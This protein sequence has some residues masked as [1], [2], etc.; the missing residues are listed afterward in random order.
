[1]EDY[2]KIVRDAIAGAPLARK[3]GIVCERVVV[4]RVVMRL[5]WTPEHTT[6]GDLVHGGA[7][8]ALVDVAA[9]GACWATPDLEPGARGTTIGFTLSFLNAGRAQDLLARGARG[10]ARA[11]DRHRRG[12]RALRRRQARRAGARHLQEVLR[13][14]VTRPTLFCDPISEPSRAV[15]WFAL[16]AGIELELRYTWLTR[17]QHRSA[18]FAAVNPRRQVPALLDGDFALSEAT[19]IIR[20]LAEVAKA[21]PVWLGETTRARARVDLLLSWYHTNLRLRSTLEYFLPVL[22]VPCIGGPRLAQERVAQ[23]R[24]RAREALAGLEELLGGAPFLGGDRPRVPDLLFASELYALDCDPELPALL[25]GLGGVRGW[26]ERLRARSGYA[27]THAGWNAVAPLIAARLR[28]GV[29]AGAGAAWIADV[30]ESA[31][32]IPGEGATGRAS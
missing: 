31:L 8:A 22:L 24:E 28:D 20:Y 18:A 23:L 17:N 14:A 6:I 11:F 3:L 29:S 26:A 32:G 2:E 10:A 7:I 5:P 9:T 25:D 27:P 13:G 15:Q 16:E 19:A 1:M 12:R 30:C 4:D 21:D